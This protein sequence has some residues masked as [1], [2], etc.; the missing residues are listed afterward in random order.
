M[1]YASTAEIV[2]LLAEVRAGPPATAV[3]RAALIHRLRDILPRVR[4]DLLY[5]EIA[6]LAA[7][8]EAGNYVSK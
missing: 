6:E 7:L 8:L 3:A 5:R 4:D 2:A 1:G